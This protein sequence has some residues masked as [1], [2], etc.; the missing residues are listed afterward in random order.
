M[1]D[2]WRQ[3]DLFSPDKFGG[4]EVHIIGCGATGSYVALF[5]AKL[6]VQNLHLWDFDSVEPHNLPNQ[7]F[8]MKDVGRTKVEALAEI[9]E[10]ASGVKATVHNEKVDGSTKLKGV[11]FL[12]VDSMDARK[13]IWSGAIKFKLEVELMVETRMAIDNGRI[14]AIR[15]ST[16]GDIRLWEGTLYSNEEAEESACTNKVVGPTVAFISSLAAWKLIKWHNGEDFEREL[17]LSCRPTIIV[18]SK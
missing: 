10:E 1:I 18:S 7:V 9:L 11:V 13:A 6:G 5:L 17:I 3:L 4:K 12:L 14:Y 8:R 2:Y 15:P 16:P